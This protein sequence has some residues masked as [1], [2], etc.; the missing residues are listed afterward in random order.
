LGTHREGGDDY[1]DAGETVVD[2]EPTEM[3]RWRHGIETSLIFLPASM[4]GVASGFKKD[5]S[6]TPDERGKINYELNKPV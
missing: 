1:L 3:Q 5:K 2:F 6:L 4:L